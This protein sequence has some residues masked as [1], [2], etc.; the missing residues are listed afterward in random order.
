MGAPK[1]ER[2]LR[3]FGDDVGLAHSCAHCQTFSS[4]LGAESRQTDEI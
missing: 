2:K 4:I 1:I 3:D